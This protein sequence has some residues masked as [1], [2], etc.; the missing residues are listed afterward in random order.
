[1]KDESEVLWHERTR[2]EIPTYAAKGAVVVVPIA[3][4]EQHGVALPLDTDCRTV[5]YVSV[6]AARLANC[7]VLVTRVIPVG[8]SPHHMMHPGT[9][10]LSAETT[11][12]VLKEVVE[13]IAT[14]GFDHIL[15]LSG[16]GGNGPAIGAAA[17]ELKFSLGRQIEA[18]AWWDGADEV[19]GAVCEGPCA[20]IGHAGE[21]EGS[22]I[23]ALRPDLVRPKWGVVPGITDDP[24]LATAEKGWY[25]LNEGAKIL[26]SRYEALYAQPGRNVIGIKPS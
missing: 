12:R 25:I 16:H 3:S 13:S 5:E 7:P 14:H 18:G 8:L 6:R 1:M 15:L 11:I 2:D 9:I 4:I 22:C 17:M 20:N 10:T 23:Q 24:Q 21:A 19:F 26:A